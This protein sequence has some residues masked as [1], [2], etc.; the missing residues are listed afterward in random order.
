[1]RYS[2]AARDVLEDRRA[3][4]ALDPKSLCTKNSPYQY[5]LSKISFFPVMKS[6]SRGGGSKGGGGYPLLL[7]VSAI[8]IHRWQQPSASDHYPMWIMMPVPGP[9]ECLRGMMG[10][11]VGQVSWTVVPSLPFPRE[12][13]KH[14]RLLPPWQPNQPENNLCRAHNTIPNL[15]N[16]ICATNATLIVLHKQF[17]PHNSVG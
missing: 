3:G 7:W 6:G 4:G 11:T 9:R 16:Q 15:P 17:C 2:A 13:P 10:A 14:T 12:A 1:M 5:F 8:L